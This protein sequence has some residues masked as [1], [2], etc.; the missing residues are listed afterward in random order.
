V[1]T[2]KVFTHESILERLDWTQIENG[3]SHYYPVSEF[4]NNLHTFDGIPIFYG[5]RHPS[6]FYKS[7][8][9]ILENEEVVLAGY[10]SN[11]EI[12]RMGRPKLKAVLNIT[13]PEIEEKIRKGEILLSS[14][15]GYKKQVDDNRILLTSPRGLHVLLYNK[16][17]GVP[18]GDPGAAICNQSNFENEEISI[19]LGYFLGSEKTADETIQVVKVSDLA[20]LIKANQAPILD[21]TQHDEL[22]K[23]NQTLETEKS[24]LIKANQALT[25]EI[26]AL[27]KQMEEAIEK[28]ETEK[29]EMFKSNQD[30]FW[31]ELEEAVQEKFSERKETELYDAVKAN[32]LI[33]DITK[34][35]MAIPRPA[36]VKAQGTKEVKELTEAEKKAVEVAE[37]QRKL[38]ATR[39]QINYAG[40]V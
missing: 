15:F 38:A 2:S 21:L 29:V 3:E 4:E 25:E 36:H 5:S 9:E 22:I 8:E 6:A 1:E 37:T 39:K 10:A 33:Q 34:F 19:S 11:P 40:G 30:R 17:L 7:V 27:K 32:Q 14:Q 31:N 23:S 18:Q 26:E 13:N 20:E 28:A 12:N 16:A 24:E 35:I